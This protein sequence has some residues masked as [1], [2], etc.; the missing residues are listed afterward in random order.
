M[1]ITPNRSLEAAQNSPDPIFADHRGY[2]PNLAKASE[3][4][5]RFT[6]EPG[7]RTRVDLEHRHFER[8]GAGGASMR[9]TVDSSGGWGGLLEMFKA[10]AEQTQ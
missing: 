8:H 9:T 5:V 3:V 1:L 6:A 10:R 7:G 4:D 2:E